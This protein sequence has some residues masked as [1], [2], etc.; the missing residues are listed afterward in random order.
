LTTIKLASRVI[1]PIA[2]IALVGLPAL[3]VAIAGEPQVDATGTA[4]TPKPGLGEPQL[5][6]NNGGGTIYNFFVQ[7]S[8]K[9][10]D[11]SAG[12]GATGRLNGT[13]TIFQGAGAGDFTADVLIDTN[14]D[15]NATGV[16]D[17]EGTVGSGRVGLSCSGTDESGDNV[18]L[19]I[20]AKAAV[21]N[22]KVALTAGKGLGFTDRSGLTFVFQGQQQ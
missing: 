10:L 19:M 6:P 9:P 20:L 18:F 13:I 11:P 14:K 5:D 7:G 16:L 21:K 15:G 2:L 4:A 3:A 22:G 8:A 12:Q 17:C 1:L